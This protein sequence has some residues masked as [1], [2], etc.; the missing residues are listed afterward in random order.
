[1]PKNRE[2][3]SHKMA[4][5]DFNYSY[6][7]NALVKKYIMPKRIVI[8][9]CTENEQILLEDYARQTIATAGLASCLIKSGGYILLDFG[10]ELQGGIDISVSS[11]SLDNSSA[12]GASVY[13]TA[14]IVFGESVSEALS[15]VGE[16]STATNDH[17]VRDM[18]VQTVPMSTMRYGNTGFR[19]VKVE[20]VGCDIQVRAI[21]G[22]LEYRD[23]EYKGSFCCNDERLNQIFNTAAYTVHLNM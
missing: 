9:E 14:R 20:A 12:K 22:V 8:S 11:V 7:K 15:R 1:M 16:G 23:L 19:F 6:E 4:L 21:K 13:G 10:S 5:S 2:G 18:T 17:S 3:L